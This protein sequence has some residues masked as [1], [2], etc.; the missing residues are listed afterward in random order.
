MKLLEIL[1]S[2][3]TK[4]SI[5]LT[6]E[7]CHQL[8]DFV[9]LLDQWNKVYNLTAV[10]DPQQM[11]GR[12]LLD[13]LTLAPYITDYQRI[14]DLGSG[15]GLPGIPLAICQSETQFTLIDSNVKKTRFLTHVLTTLALENVTVIHQRTEQYFP[16]QLYDCLTARAFAPPDKIMSIAGHLCRPGGALL[17]M[18]AD[19][20]ELDLSGNEDF[21]LQSISPVQVY[22]ESAS[23]HIV[24]FTRRLS[25]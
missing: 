14:A 1:E 19:V 18:T 6:G 11:I 5:Q 23:R 12:H 21:L 7:Q 24:K 20:D 10:R 22:N 3:L 2:G 13:S 9:K 4:Q 16:D 8:V 25:I 15:G 17:L